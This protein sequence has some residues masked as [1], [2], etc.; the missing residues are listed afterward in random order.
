[1]STN[2]YSII[3]CDRCSFSEHIPIGEKDQNIKRYSLIETESKNKLTYY[4]DL[5]NRCLSDAQ[6]FFKGAG[7]FPSKAD[8]TTAPL[9]CPWC[10]KLHID[11]GVWATKPHHTHLCITDATGAGCGKTW[12]LDEYVFGSEVKLPT[13]YEID[14]SFSD[15]E[16]VKKIHNAEEPKE[17]LSENIGEKPTSGSDPESLEPF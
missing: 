16:D 14:P 8:S 15:V 7:K 12:R 1:M 9:Y 3:K 17:S 6:D 5:C 2:N 10:G 11:S 13:Q 4:I